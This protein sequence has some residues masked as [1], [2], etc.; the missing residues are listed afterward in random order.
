MTELLFYEDVNQKQCDA[1]VVAVGD[2]GI[3]LDRTVFYPVGGG[4]PGDSGVLR[5][6]HGTEVVAVDDRDIALPGGY[7]TDLVAV[8]ALGWAG[9]IGHQAP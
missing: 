6:Q 7:R 2:D 5:L 1:R 8:T 4:Q 9:E 3:V